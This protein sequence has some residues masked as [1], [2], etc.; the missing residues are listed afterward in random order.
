[1][2]KRQARQRETP[3][4]FHA[5][6]GADLVEIHLR[7][8]P[9]QAD[10]M[11]VVAPA[12]RVMVA[13]GAEGLERFQTATEAGFAQGLQVMRVQGPG[14]AAFPLCQQPIAML[15]N[16]G[17]GGV[18]RWPADVGEDA[19]RGVVPEAA[20]F[21]LAGGGFGP[22]FG[23]AYETVAVAGA[24]FVEGKRVHHAVA[25]E[26]VAEGPSAQFTAAWPDA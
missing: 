6:A 17:V 25:V 22:V 2:Q 21:N 5:P 1:V 23:R 26:P 20:F 15:D 16:T 3:A 10:A 4:P 11:V 14:A 24:L 13:V 8:V 18:G 19:A 7:A 12:V 9:P